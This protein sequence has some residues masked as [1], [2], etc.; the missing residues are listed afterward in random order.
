MAK[1]IR[2]HEH[3]GPEVLRLEEVEVGEPGPGEVRLRQT[4]VGLNF[5]DVYHRTGLYPLPALPAVLGMEGAGVVEA[6]GEG[7]TEVRP[8]DR[9]AYAGLP[10]GAYAEVRLIPAHRLVPLPDDIDDVQAAGVMLQGMTAQ[11]LLRRTYRVQAGETILVHAAAGG[12]GLILCQWA[13]HLG[14]TVIGTVGSAE[15]AELARAHGCHHP[16]NYREEDFVARVRELTGGEGVPVVYD[17]VGRDTFMGSLDCLRPLGMM[18]SFGQASGP[19]P[20]LDIG[21]LAQKGSLY[22]TRPTL[23]TYTARREDLLASARELFEVVR[24]GAVRIEV[25]QTY[26]LAEAAQAHRDLEARRTTGSTVLIPGC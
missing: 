1:A 26:P 24:S 6:V 19:V 23:M 25:R 9:V 18:V 13:R 5:I 2:I 11:Y 3:G 10:V 17:S 4:A 16:V 8:G 20:P 22:L 12:V 14:A 15:K 21:V 7:V